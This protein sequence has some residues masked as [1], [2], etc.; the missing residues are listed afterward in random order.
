VINSAVLCFVIVI[1]RN[2]SLYVNLSHTS[3]LNTCLATRTYTLLS[4]MTHSTASQY[5]V[6]TG[7]VNRKVAAKSGNFTQGE[8]LH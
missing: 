3:L 5:W 1:L 7:D 6:R 2:D 8:Y 4:H